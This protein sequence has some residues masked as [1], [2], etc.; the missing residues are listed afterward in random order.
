MLSLN[1][2]DWYLYSFAIKY[3]ISVKAFPALKEIV[4]LKP[5][6]RQIVKESIK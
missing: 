1:Y 3:E 4:V 5:Q 6:T 2:Y